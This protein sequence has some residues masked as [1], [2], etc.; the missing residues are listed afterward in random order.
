MDNSIYANA[1]AIALQ[2]TLIGID[3]LNRMIECSSKEEA[4]KILNEVNFGDGVS[5]DGGDFELIISTEEDKFSQFIRENSPSENFKKYLLIGNDYHNAE[6]F[7][8][9]KY[10]KSDVSNM[11]VSDG[12]INAEKL[13]DDILSDNYSSFSKNLQSALIEADNLFVFGNPDGKS[14]SSIFKKA[15]YSELFE[16]A[17]KEKLLKKLFSVKA[18]A[19]NIS[20]CFRTRDYSQAKEM[21]V[22]GGTLDETALKGLCEDTVENLKDKIKFSENRK[23]IE[24]AIEDFSKGTTLTEFEKVAD[25]YSLALLKERKYDVD[26]YRPFMLYAFYKRAEIK[27]V[28][29]ILSCI[30]NGIDKNEIKSRVRETYEG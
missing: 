14:I 23:L 1:R 29:I 16:I 21:F 2:N 7:L 28:R 8:R 22:K 25:G 18:D 12:F 19:V 17:S 10:L 15:L 20:I 5:S 6:V 3:R 24:I 13:K 11:V 4:L 26:G 30:D 9:S 27:N